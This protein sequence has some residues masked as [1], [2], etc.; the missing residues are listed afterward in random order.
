MNQLVRE[1]PIN[2]SRWISLHDMQLTKVIFQKNSVV[3]FFEN[4]FNI[5][6][7][8]NVYRKTRGNINLLNCD[9]SDFTCSIIERRKT[10]QGVKLKGRPITLEGLNKMLVG[11]K[12]HVELFLELYDFNHLYWRGEMHPYK[13]ILNRRLAPLVIIEAMDF[14]PMVYSWE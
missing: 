14:F 12:K 7:D 6:E 5:I 3:F 9:S 10:K 1:S 13:Q 2:G 4:G 11:E 8:D